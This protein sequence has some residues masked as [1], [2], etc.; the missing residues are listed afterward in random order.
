LPAAIPQS[1]YLDGFPWPDGNS[2]SRRIEKCAIRSPY[3]SLCDCPADIAAVPDHWTSTEQTDDKHPFRLATSPARGFLNSTFSTRRRPRWRKS[4]G[5]PL[6]SS[7][8]AAHVR[9]GDADYVV[10]GNTR[11]KVHL[12]ANCFQAGAAAC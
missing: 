7:D 6:L 9:I 10:L 11:G 2:D 3:K 8:D 1:H 4:N 12:H 5:R